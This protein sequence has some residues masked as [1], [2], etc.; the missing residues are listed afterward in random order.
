[1][2]FYF[3][4]RCTDSVTFISAKSQIDEPSSNS[5]QIFYVYFWTDSLN[6]NFI[7]CCPKM[8]E[9]W[10]GKKKPRICSSL[11]N[12]WIKNFYLFWNEIVILWIIQTNILIFFNCIVFA[13][14]S[15]SICET[16]CSKEPLILIPGNLFL[17]K[18]DCV[19]MYVTSVE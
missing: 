17:R 8:N 10:I 19:T 2:N 11:S 9:I 7:N 6:S 3:I 1:M 5:N 4:Y 15:F 16:I 18:K 12:F 13:S 14:T